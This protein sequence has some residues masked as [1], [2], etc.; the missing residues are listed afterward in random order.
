M[1]SFSRREFLKTGVAASALASTLPLKAERATATDLVTLGRSDVK[2]TRL[3]LGTGSF[4][5]RIQQQIGQ[6]GLTRLVHHA[7][8]R[9]IR[10]F[11]TSE[12]YGASQQMLAVALKGIPR[13]NYTL[14][15]KVT[16]REGADPAAKLDELRKNSD[17][18]YFDIMLLHFQHT[19]TWVADTAKW[20][21]AILEAEQ[22]KAIKSHG[23]SVHGLQ[24]LRLMPGNQWLDVAMIRMN[25]KGT[26]MDAEQYD[27]RGLGDVDE[28]VKHVKQVKKEGMGVISMKLIGEGTFNHEDRQKAMRFAFR[29]AGVDC[30]TVGYKNTDE[31]DEAID[32]L[33][34]ALG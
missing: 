11:E 33:N 9:G 3:A 32:N 4:G 8:D 34:L 10:F 16:T 5:G 24:A 29:N 28:V 31:I 22:K 14:M 1:T 7:Y 20:Q 21:D 6:E 12:S 2:V 26:I 23:A 25:H 15:S 19:G 17:T 18:D 27:T 13:D 30:V